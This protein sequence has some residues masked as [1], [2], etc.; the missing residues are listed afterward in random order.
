MRCLVLI[1][2]ERN[3]STYTNSIHCLAGFMKT[4]FLELVSAHLTFI[5][6]LNCFGK[7]LFPSLRCQIIL[8]DHIVRPL[9]LQA[10]HIRIFISIGLSSLS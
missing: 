7:G 3:R 1:G 8:Y 6:E 10:M 5:I 2:I 9:E 4:S